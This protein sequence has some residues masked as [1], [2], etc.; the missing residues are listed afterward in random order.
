[1]AVYLLTYDLAGEDGSGDY[2]LLWGELRRLGAHR[3]LESAWLLDFDAHPE[4][5]LSSFKA[6]LNEEDRLFVTALRKGEF[7]YT[8]AR[9]GTNDWLDGS[10]LD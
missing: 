8:K 9:S 2:D 5:L 4:A 3:M 10:R 6:F 7:T 1:M